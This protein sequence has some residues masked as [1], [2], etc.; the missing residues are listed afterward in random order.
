MLGGGGA[1]GAGTPLHATAGGGGGGYSHHGRSGDYS[2]QNPHQQQYDTT[3]VGATATAG[4]HG[5]STAY[6]GGVAGFRR[7]AA[8]YPRLHTGALQWVWSAVVWYFWTAVWLL[9]MPWRV[10]RW[11]APHFLQPPLQWAEDTAL[12]LAAP[13]TRLAGDAVHGA[14]ALADRAIAGGSRAVSSLHT[15]NV[16]HWL[17]AYEAYLW[18]LMHRAHEMERHGWEGLLRRSLARRSV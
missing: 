14:L 10:T 12:W 4:T 18:L 11:L 6:G 1:G 3:P 7:L 9:S 15:S 8:R 5:S 17:T 2:P 16:H 13:P